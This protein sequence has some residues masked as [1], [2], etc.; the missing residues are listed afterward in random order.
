MI[1]IPTE[2]TN[3]QRRQLIDTQQVYAAW[4][5]SREAA[6][7][8]MLWLKRRG[9]DYLHQKIGQHERPLSK[10]PSSSGALVAAGRRLS[11]PGA[12]AGTC[13]NAFS[14]TRSCMAT[15]AP[16]PARGLAAEGSGC[17]HE[18]VRSPS[19]SS[20]APKPCRLV[21]DSCGDP[22]TAPEAPVV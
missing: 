6:R 13:S 14:E 7:G 9:I 17:P 10:G 3:E 11:R 4:R 21:F 2:L 22:Q 1:R 8:H 18:L 16:A 15:G 20:P 5:G 12:I 19:P